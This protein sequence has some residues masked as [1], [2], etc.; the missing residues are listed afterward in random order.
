MAHGKSKL[1][2]TWNLIAKRS[3]VKKILNFE[4]FCTP[5]EALRWS[6]VRHTPPRTMTTASDPILSLV[7][8]RI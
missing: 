6:G 5:N 7:A 8:H 2:G 4:Q 1:Y 3:S